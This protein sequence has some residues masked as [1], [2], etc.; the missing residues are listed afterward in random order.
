MNESKQTRFIGSFTIKGAGHHGSLQIDDHDSTL[1]IYSD[2]FFNIDD[3][4]LRCIK[5]I[6]KEGARVSAIECIPSSICGRSSYHGI[7]KHYATLHPNFVVVGHDYL[8]PNDNC[9]ESISFTFPAAKNLFYDLGTFGHIREKRDLPLSYIRQMLRSAKGSPRKRRRGGT[10]DL[11]YRWDRGPIIEC[12]HPFGKLTA[13]NATAERLTYPGGISLDNQVRIT[14]SFTDPSSLGKSL[15]ICYDAMGFFELTAQSRQILD[16]ITITK[17]G[18]EEFLPL[19]LYIVN[20][21]TTT[22]DKVIPGDTLI[23]GGMHSE[24]FSSVLSSWLFTSEERGPPRR[25][26]SEGAREGNNYTINRL[27]SAANSFDLL[28]KLDFVKPESLPEKVQSL[29]NEIESKIRLFKAE[30]IDLGEYVQRLLNNLGHSRSLNLRAKILQ[31][32]DSTPPFLKEKLPR[33]PEAIVFSVNCRNFFVH[34]AE[35][36]LSRTDAHEFVPFFTDTL[37]FV[38][39]VTELTYCGW[40]IGRWNKDAYSSSP[41]KNYMR[42]FSMNMIQLDA[43]TARY[44]AKKGNSAPPE[45]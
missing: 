27:I 18:S 43:G 33:M 9:I 22:R 4:D 8:D 41:L 40:D 42:N 12:D 21:E 28:P 13:W 35:F 30:N 11:Y 17:L 34:G 2:N 7:I 44:K 20:T 5:G 45:S 1:D 10:I 16:E 24:E 14:V 38:F 15:K 36:K 26:F 23:N 32:W 39:S 29:Y 37:E 19:Q 3:D 31:K 6:S 25:R